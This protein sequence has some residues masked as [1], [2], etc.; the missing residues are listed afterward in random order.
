MYI[1][2]DPR[3]HCFIISK[4]TFICFQLKFSTNY[5][6]LIKIKCFKMSGPLTK[7]ERELK[8]RRFIQMKWSKRKSQVIID[9]LGE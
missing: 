6:I 1:V 9:E 5:L 4:Q 8:F 2:C 3:K 7:E